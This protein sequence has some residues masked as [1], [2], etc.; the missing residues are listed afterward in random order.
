M[1]LLFGLKTTL[2]NLP[3]RMATCQ[4]CGRF[5]HHHLQER[6][7]KFTLFFIPVFTTSKTFNITCTN[8]GQSSTIKSRQKNALIS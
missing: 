3:G 5:V 7:T 4:Y 2:R 6:A 1:F 8:C